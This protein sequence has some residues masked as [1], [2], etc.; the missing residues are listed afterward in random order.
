MRIAGLGA[1]DFFLSSSFFCSTVVQYNHVRCAVTEQ[2]NA[3]TKQTRQHTSFRKN[4]S[5]S[6]SFL[7]P[8]SV[9]I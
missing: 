9:Q 5:A 4:M 1:S 7:P 3:I 6:V 8:Q 2:V